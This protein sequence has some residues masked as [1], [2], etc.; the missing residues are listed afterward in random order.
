MISKRSWRRGAGDMPAF[1]DRHLIKQYNN[2]K[3]SV[4]RKD[5]RRYAYV[6]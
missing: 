3:R 1:F 6:S 2:T 4:P 5:R